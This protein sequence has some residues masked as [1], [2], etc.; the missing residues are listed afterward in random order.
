VYTSEEGIDFSKVGD[1]SQP[2]QHSDDV[3]LFESELDDNGQA[4]YH[5]K[6]RCMPTC[7]YVLARFWLRV[8]KVLLRAFETRVWVEHATSEVV[9]EYCEKEV[10]WS[11]LKALGHI[12]MADSSLSR[13]EDEACTHMQQVGDTQT[14]RIKSVEI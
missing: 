5:V 14:T 3:D 12:S 7:T 4:R 9:R 1:T 13:R 2:I 10:A 6:V 11:S 8:D